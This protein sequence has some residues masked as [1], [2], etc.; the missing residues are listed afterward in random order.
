VINRGLHHRDE[1]V[2]VFILDHV[3]LDGARV[4]RSL[5]SKLLRLRRKVCTYRSTVTSVRLLVSWAQNAV[6]VSFVEVSFLNHVGASALLHRLLSLL[7]RLRRRIVN[8][9]GSTFTHAIYHTSKIVN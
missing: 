2:L 1:L 6:Y 5:V 7:I 3:Y 8:C 9:I 4:L